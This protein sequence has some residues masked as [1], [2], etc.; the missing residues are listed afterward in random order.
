MRALSDREF[1]LSSPYFDAALDC[2]YILLNTPGVYT[3]FPFDTITRPSVLDLSFANLSAAPLV[4]S[5][6][7]PLPSTGSDHVPI[8][9]TLGPPHVLLPPPAPHWDLLDWNAM[10]EALKDF[11][12]IGRAH[13]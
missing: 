7:T 3:R 12:E 10:S 9:V 8:V 1:H 6:D 5:W 2:L 13:V 4:T 11:A